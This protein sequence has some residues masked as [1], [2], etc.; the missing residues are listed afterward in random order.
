MAA[1]GYWFV[2][3]L[4]FLLVVSMAG[5]ASEASPSRPVVHYFD[6]DV[7]AGRF[8][9]WNESLPSRIARVSGSLQMIEARKD[10]N[11]CRALA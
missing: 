10:R 1:I 7:P 6:C 9:E 3:V 8:S 4:F 5:C 2:R 11:G